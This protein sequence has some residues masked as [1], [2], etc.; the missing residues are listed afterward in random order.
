MF[1]KTKDI[2]P[3]LSIPSAEQELALSPGV[4]QMGQQ[5]GGL[6]AFS[7]SFK[8]GH[9]NE[10]FGVSEQ[11]IWLGAADFENAPFRVTMA[12]EMIFSAG[13]DGGDQLVIS[14]TDL[15]ILLYIAGVP[16]ALFGKQVGGFV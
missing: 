6:S 4:I 8:R 13:E 2:S 10:V 14:A 16:Q 12:G 5:I 11:G 9:G 7:S 1:K 15:R 3:S